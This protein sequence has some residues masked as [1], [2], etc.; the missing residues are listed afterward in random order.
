MSR[1]DRDSFIRHDE[2]LVLRRA[3]QSPADP[4]DEAS[5]RCAP[6]SRR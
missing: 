3:A 1:A 4:L 5:I 2:K 6:A